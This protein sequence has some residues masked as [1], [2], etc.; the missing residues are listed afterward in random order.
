[1][2]LELLVQVGHEDPRFTLR[3]YTQATKRR[4][5]LARPQLRAFDRAIEWASVG[6]APLADVEELR[7]PVAA[8]R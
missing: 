1:L 7:T 6:S 5:R 8:G 2:F 3:V 4:D